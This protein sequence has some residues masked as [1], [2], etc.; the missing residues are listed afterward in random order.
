L[1]AIVSE[2]MRAPGLRVDLHQRTNGTGKIVIEFDDA[3]TRD[4]ALEQL[5]SLVP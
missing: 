1:L 4:A 2:V 3:R 5:R